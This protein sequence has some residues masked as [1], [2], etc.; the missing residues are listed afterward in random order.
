MVKYA[1]EDEFTGSSGSAPDP[2]SWTFDTGA[3][4]GNNGLQHYSDS[5]ENSFLDGQGHLVIRAIKSG[6]TYTSARLKTEGLWARSHGTFEARIKLDRAQGTWPAWW[7]LGDTID[8]VGWPWCGEVD[9]LEVYGQPG[10]SSDSTVHTA[11]SD[12]NDQ[13]KEIAVP[14]G[15][16]TGWHTWR[17]RNNIDTGNIQFYKDY[18]PG[19]QPY[20]TVRPADLPNWPFNKPGTTGV[21]LFLILNLA[22]G[23]DGGGDVPS[24]FQSAEML[25]DYVRVW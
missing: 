14:G 3:G 5:R 20:L 15:V 22:V 24:S 13:S 8:Q 16:D 4:W 10:W 17:C 23:G 12:G 6:D 19:V 2:A 18:A 9:V 7:M 11:A 21:P 25:V 1:F